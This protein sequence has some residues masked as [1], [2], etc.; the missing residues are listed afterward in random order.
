VASENIECGTGRSYF[1]YFQF[2]DMVL[3]SSM[4]NKLLSGLRIWG[5]CGYEAVRTTR[6]TALL[7]V[8]VRI[9]KALIY[10]VRNKK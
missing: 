5:F 1:L 6:Y 7:T 2:Q 3:S 9:Q 10:K 8:I 4:L